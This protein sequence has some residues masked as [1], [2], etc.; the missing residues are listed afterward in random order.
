VGQAFSLPL[1][2]TH[3]AAAAL[4]LTWM[5][6]AGCNR[7]VPTSGYVLVYRL[8]RGEKVDPATMAAAVQSRLR[9]TG[10]SQATANPH[11]NGVKIFLPGADQK[12]AQLAKD[13]VTR[14]GHLEFQ[15]VAERGIHNMEIEAA[16][17]DDPQAAPSTEATYKWVL[18]DPRV[19]TDEKT[20]LRM[21]AR[22]QQEILVIV[23]RDLAVEGSDL[24][25]AKVATDSQSKPCIECTLGPS[26]M[27]KMQALSESNIDRRMGIVFDDVLVTAPTIRWRF[28]SHFRLSGSF[29]ADEVELMVDL[30]RSGSLPGRLEREPV[31]EQYIAPK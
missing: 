14:L 1:S 26:G 12:A 30:L 10:F 19:T 27:P 31:S 4:F 3:R 15:I 22:G 25:S 29:S 2:M 18:L 7:A 16:T 11:E 24:K 21:N 8:A 20:V 9:G 6:I 28:A 23:D 5:L 17:K 13:V